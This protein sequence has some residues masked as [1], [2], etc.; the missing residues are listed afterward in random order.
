MDVAVA[1]PVA[2][3][4]LGMRQDHSD[5]GYLTTA[6]GC[7]K[8][9][10]RADAI[11]VAG[12]DLVESGDGW[13]VGHDDGD[14]DGQPPAVCEPFME[15]ADLPTVRGTADEQQVR[16]GIRVSVFQAQAIG[17][18]SGTPGDIDTESGFEQRVPHGLHAQHIACGG[19]AVKK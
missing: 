13:V 15:L 12:D 16:V 18:Q 1:L 3:L 17:T 6:R 10:V 4:V 14:S 7:G 9:A 8:V 11:P 19:L 5:H 2:V